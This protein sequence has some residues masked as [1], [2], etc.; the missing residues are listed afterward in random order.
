MENYKNKLR[1]SYKR[2]EKLILIHSIQ[3]YLVAV[4]ML[5]GYRN[6]KSGLLEFALFNLGKIISKI[7]FNKLLMNQG[8][9]KITLIFSNLLL[10]ISFFTIN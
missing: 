2:N 8:K 1:K 4:L 6:F 9:M 10:I 3:F 5:F 7:I